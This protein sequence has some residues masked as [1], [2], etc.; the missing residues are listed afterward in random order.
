M[1]VIVEHSSRISTDGMD[2]MVLHN[3]GEDSLLGA[4]CFWTSLCSQ[5]LP[6]RAVGSRMAPDRVLKR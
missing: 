1:R 3:T 6:N 4:P 2:T 5:R